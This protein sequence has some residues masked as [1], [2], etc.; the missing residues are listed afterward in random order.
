MILRRL[1]EAIRR[2]DWFVVVLEVLIVVVGIFIGLQVDDWNKYRQDRALEQVYLDRLYADFEGSIEDHNQNALW[3]WMRVAT[4]RFALE[5]LRAGTRPEGEEWSL[6]SK[7]LALI[8]VHNPIRRRWGTV[9]ELKAT[10]NIT[11]LQD[12]TLINMI[13]RAEVVHDRAQ[14]IMNR[15]EDEL[16]LLR[17]EITA[18]FEEQDINYDAYGDANVKVNFEE[19]A[20]DQ[21]FLNILSTAVERSGTQYAFSDD[22]ILAIQELR[23]YLAERLGKVPSNT[24][25]DA[26]EYILH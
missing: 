25:E 12:Q 3:D 9:E 15:S 4:S 20:A 26:S 8:G 11:L 6:F 16:T 24:V 17:G 13:A 23:D 19:L 5:T 22:S 1:S 10:G 18:R 7:G 2:Q 14:R 21:R